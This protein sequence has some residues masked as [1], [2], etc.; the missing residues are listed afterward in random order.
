[1]SDWNEEEH[2]RDKGKTIAV[3]FSAHVEPAVDAAQVV[4][5][6]DSLIAELMA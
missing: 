6:V 2:K 3:T 5:V 4:R 1:M